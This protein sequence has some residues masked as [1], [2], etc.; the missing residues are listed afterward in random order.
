MSPPLYVINIQAD[1]KLKNS[2]TSRSGGSTLADIPSTG[3]ALENLS[4]A[5][6]A[7]RNQ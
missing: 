4:G 3:T 1:S 5:A 7:I 6:L 2:I